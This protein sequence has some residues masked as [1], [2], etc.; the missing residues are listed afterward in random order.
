MWKHTCLKTFV[1]F[2]GGGG[3]EGGGGGCLMQTVKVET[4]RNILENVYDKFFH[5]KNF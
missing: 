5:G 4:F 3:C 1:N 2:R